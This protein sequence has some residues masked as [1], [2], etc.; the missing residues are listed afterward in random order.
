MP[1]RL[2]A[3][4]HRIEHPKY[5]AKII[6]NN[7]R[8]S[9][10]GQAQL[11]FLDTAPELIPDLRQAFFVESIRDLDLDFG[12]TR[13]RFR[14]HFFE[15]R[16]LLEGGLDDVGDL[17]FHLNGTGA[18]VGRNDIGVMHGKGRVFESADGL[19][20]PPAAEK[21]NEGND[22]RIDRVIDCPSSNAILCGY[23]VHQCSSWVMA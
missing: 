18:W 11:G 5:V 2:T 19:D 13:D 3:R 15:I 17:V 1:R 10:R 12:S 20:A 7:R 16:Q 14:N 9:R 8:P 4:A 6:F 21:A 22:T 23:R